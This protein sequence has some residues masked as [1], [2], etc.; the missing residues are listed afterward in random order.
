MSVQ[1]WEAYEL[2]GDFQGKQHSFPFFI[3]PGEGQWLDSSRERVL[4]ND[5][6]EL[7]EVF[8]QRMPQLGQNGLQLVCVL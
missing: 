3:R 2:T 5:V 4:S 7:F 8:A 6:P 1:T